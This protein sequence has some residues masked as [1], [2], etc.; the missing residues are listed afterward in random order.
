[1][2]SSAL[3]ADEV[4]VEVRVPIPPA[5]T[6]G[7]Y[8]KYPD[9]ASGYAVVGVAA[10]VTLGGG[11]V[12]ERARVAMTGLAPYASRLVGVESALSGKP[13]TAEQI[14]AAASR[15]AEGL[16]VRDTVGGDQTYKANLA[17]VYAKRAIDRAN[18]GART[19]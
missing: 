8:E 13:A 2:F 11:D 5:R 16:E 19:A 10:V 14:E 3:A 7:A 12:V 9:P 17:R 18:N 15:A 1:M 6:G 4:L